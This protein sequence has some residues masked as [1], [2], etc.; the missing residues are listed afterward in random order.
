MVP[1][2]GSALGRAIIAA[3][4]N[5]PNSE[6]TK[7]LG[8]SLDGI[9]MVYE[10]APS[11]VVGQETK[12]GRTQLYVMMT[13]EHHFLICTLTKY[14]DKKSAPGMQIIDGN[15]PFD[16]QKVVGDATAVRTWAEDY[17]INGPKIC[18]AV[19]FADAR[20]VKA[21]ESSCFSKLFG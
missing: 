14:D 13:N 18:L 9:N 17:V 2:E 4:E 8:E 15:G 20:N 12:D 21:E 7:E 10:I 5:L 3:R 1:I 6:Q 16:P 19:P 11:L